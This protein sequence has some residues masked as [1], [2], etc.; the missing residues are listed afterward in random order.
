MK[1]L[2]LKLYQNLCNYR[3]EGSFG[4]IQTY[5]LPT[6]SMIRGMVHN[7]LD[8]NEY[9][10]LKVSNQGKSDGVITGI[11]KVYKFDREPC[12]RPDNPY[13]V[14]VRNSEKTATHGIYFID[15][16]V[17][18]KST[19]HIYFEKNNEYLLQK[20]YDKAL[21]KLIILGRNEDFALIEDIKITDLQNFKGRDRDA[22]TKLPIFLPEKFIFEKTGTTYRLPFFYDYTSSFEDNRIFHFIEVCFV[23]DNISLRK[24]FIYKDS[25][26]D[27]VCF[28]ECNEDIYV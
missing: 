15:L 22:R 21:E 7:I 17:N 3:K 6:P 28:L 14:L 13:R 2:K 11:Q 19:I 4:Y 27:I 10:P 24:E 26:D 23:G 8:V 5:P 18:M 12:S 25:D 1:A 16:H 20:C 9:I